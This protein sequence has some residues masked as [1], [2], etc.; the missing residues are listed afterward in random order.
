[1]IVEEP[2]REIDRKLRRASVVVTWVGIATVLAAGVHRPIHWHSRNEWVRPARVLRLTVR[3]TLLD[4]GLGVSVPS[5]LAASGL[6]RAAAG[7]DSRD[8]T[9][10]EV[11]GAAA[12]VYQRAR[13]ILIP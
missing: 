7:D 13:C 11:A 5:V 9:L 10:V 8:R 3:K 2:A 1:M 4:G 12:T 6:W